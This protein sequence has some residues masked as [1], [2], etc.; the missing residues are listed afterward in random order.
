V[1]RVVEMLENGNKADLQLEEDVV[2]S[3]LAFSMCLIIKLRI[4]NK[5][6]LLIAYNQ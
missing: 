4:N 6:Q 5:I 2:E 1:V 3:K